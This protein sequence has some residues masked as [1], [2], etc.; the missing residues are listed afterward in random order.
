MLTVPVQCYFSIITLKLLLAVLCNLFPRGENEGICI[1]KNL[2]PFSHMHFP[3]NIWSKGLVDL[4]R[5][6]SI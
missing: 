2:Y 6:K 4:A 1:E 5:A 3:H